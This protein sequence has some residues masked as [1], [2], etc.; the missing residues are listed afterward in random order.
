MGNDVW[1][2]SSDIPYWWRVTTQISV[3]LLI[4]WGQFLAN[5]TN[6]P[7]LGRICLMGLFFELVTWYL[8]HSCRGWV[9]WRSLR[10][11][12]FKRQTATGGKRVSAFLGSCLVHIFGQLNRLY[13]RKETKQ[14]K[15]GS[16]TI[17]RTISGMFNILLQEK[18]QSDVRS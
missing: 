2:T 3:V 9:I 11:G 4:G 8:I 15:F 7:D 5:E 1:V 14:Y 17:N 12:V 18:S 13:K 10:N 16:K 6:Y